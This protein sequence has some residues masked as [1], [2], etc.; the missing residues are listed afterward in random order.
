MR[1]KKAALALVSASAKCAH[2]HVCLHINFHFVICTD[3]S[4]KIY[5]HRLSAPTVGANNP[6]L[7]VIKKTFVTLEFLFSE[8]NRAPAWCDRV[9]WK[10]EGI[11]QTVYRSHPQLKISDHKPVSTLFESEVLLDFYKHYL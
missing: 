11:H 9:L 8:K 7:F 4:V 10:G 6:L 5:F 3:R 2:Y 1:Q